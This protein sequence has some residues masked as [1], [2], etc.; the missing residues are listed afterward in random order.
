M[1]APKTLLGAVK[2]FANADRA[3]AY[4]V[5]TRWPY[6]VAC[7]RQG[8]G[9]AAVQFIATRK[10]WRCKECKKQFTVK[11]GTIFEDSPIPLTKWLP[12][13]WLL[14]NTKNGTSSCELARALGVTQK[15]A[16]FMLHRVREAMKA[17][18]YQD[19]L[20]GYVEADETYVGGKAKNRHAAPYSAVKK[21]GARRKRSLGPS[22]GKAIV[23]GMIQRYGGR[24]RAMTVHETTGAH[25]KGRIRTH[26]QKGSTI[27]TDAHRA[28]IGLDAEYLHYVV[29]HAVRYVEGHVHTNS[30]ENFWS[31]LKRTLHGTYIAAR[32]E[33]LD[34]YVDEQVFR[35]NEREDNDGGRFV[36]ALK[37]A[38][39]K[40]LTYAQLTEKGSR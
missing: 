14:V 30:I 36:K 19:K 33:H 10:L 32:P 23:M 11:V 18:E 16:W 12:A 13:V 17:P 35:F 8:C 25:L 34:A 9:S 7:P 1:D 39:G 40:R 15:T 22:H 31:C 5:A 20:S 4:A 24:V 29:I 21:D 6:G 2:Y 37:G 27:Y 28:Y 26:V 3:H 38:D